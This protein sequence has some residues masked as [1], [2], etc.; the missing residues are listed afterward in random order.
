MELIGHKR[1]VL[2]IEWHPTASNVLFSA[3]YDHLVKFLK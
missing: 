2:H 3:G 1:K